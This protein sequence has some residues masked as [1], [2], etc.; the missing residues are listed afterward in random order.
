MSTLLIT[1]L[2]AQILSAYQVLGQPEQ[3][4]LKTEPQSYVAPVSYP[5]E[6]FEINVTI[7]NLQAS[8]QLIGVHFRLSYDPS[9]IEVVGVAEGSFLAGFPQ[10]PSPPYTFFVS[11]VEN[12]GLYGPHIVVG[13]MLLPNDTG[14]WPG[15]YPEG[16]GTIAT[17]TF[18]QIYQPIY[19]EPPASCS[20]EFLEVKLLDSNGD[21][22]SC[23]TQ[24]GYYEA[25]PLYVPSLFVEPL[26]YNATSRNETFDI[27]IN[28][29]VD[30]RWRLIGV[31]FRLSYDPSL[32]EVVGV[33]EGSFLAGF[34]QRPS[35]PYTFFVS[36]VENDGLYGPHIVVGAMLLPN[37][38]GQWPGPYPEGNGTIATITFRVLQGPPSSCNF[39][40]VDVKLL[41]VNGNR[42][43]FETKGGHYGIFVETLYHQIAWEEQTYT[44]VTE[45]NVVVNPWPMHFDQAHRALYF[46][47]TGPNG[48]VGYCNVTIPKVLLNAPND[49]WLI[50]A[51]GRII[52][53]Q[54][55][56]NETHTSLFFTCPLSTCTVYIFGTE[57]IPEFSTAVLI[58]F[59]TLALFAIVSIKTAGS[60]RHRTSP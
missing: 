57:V 42:I 37:D 23:E 21:E 59:L 25:S 40:L 16:N 28:L 51:S 49:Q 17:I 44:V 1:F 20:L 47:L 19:P 13:A 11:Y 56:E 22:I 35:P 53:Y 18:K 38:T 24:D 48:T 46:N 58:V 36:Y 9:L 3:P 26:S 27:N 54:L 33:A 50:I 8:K 32:I 39:G 30:G 7:N 34:P 60:K 6:T 4:T 31:H 29:N 52:E 41:D 10:R 45:S 43:L 5:Y 12:D 15:P 55:S 2:C 14:Q